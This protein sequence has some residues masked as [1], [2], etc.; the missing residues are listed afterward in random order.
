MR[1][2]YISNEA[3]RRNAS[4]TRVTGKTV[5]RCKENVRK[6][7]MSTDCDVRL[8]ILKGSPYTYHLKRRHMDM[9]LCRKR[10]GKGQPGSTRAGWNT[11]LYICSPTLI[12][13]KCTERAATAG[14]Q[15]V[16]EDGRTTVATSGQGGERG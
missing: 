6:Q 16:T 8:V 3:A 7:V 10:P 13:T 2:R 1:R 15:L 5:A 12:C 9:A 11:L 14:V 4:A